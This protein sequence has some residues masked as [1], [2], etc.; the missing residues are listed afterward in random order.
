[1][2]IPESVKKRLAHFFCCYSIAITLY[3]VFKPDAEI[4]WAI[5]F[6]AGFALACVI[7]AI[8]EEKLKK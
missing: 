4:W 8:I 3:L 7:G 1:M 6:A 2:K 5:V